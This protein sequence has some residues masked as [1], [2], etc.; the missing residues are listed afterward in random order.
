MADQQE[1]THDAP[2]FDW[3]D[4]ALDNETP[5]PSEHTPSELSAESAKYTTGTTTSST[6]QETARP[7]ARP[8]L[9]E[10]F[11]DE[12]MDDG[13]FGLG[14]MFMNG[15]NFT[16]IVFTFLAI[17]VGSDQAISDEQLEIIRSCIQKIA[18]PTWVNR[19]PG[20]LGE[21]KHGKL[22]A[23]EYLILFTVILPLILPELWWTSDGSIPPDQEYALLECLDHLVAA[24]ALITSFKTS[25]SN[26]EAFTRRYKAYRESI[27]RLFPTA[28][29]LPNH[30]YAMHYEELLKEWGPLAGLSEFPG[31]R[32][33][34]MLQKT[35]TNGHLCEP[36]L[37]R[38]L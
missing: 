27:T 31:E 29:S 28:S 30:H 9:T 4:E 10:E 24:T 25:D 13:T 16:G 21:K 5:Q 38:Q 23:Q 17:Q 6:S 33:N 26:A 14:L 19:P 3:D 2:E 18:L 12:D 35:N 8:F 22:K 1:W 20:N 36:F 7:S 37:P 11:P 34:G 32:M 15:F